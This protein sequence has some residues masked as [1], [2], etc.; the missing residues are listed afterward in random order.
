MPDEK[1]Q[2]PKKPWFKP[3]RHGPG[4]HPSTWQGGLI[5]IAAV[6]VLV[7]IVYF[8]LSLR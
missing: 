1:E 5:L 6:V 3:N 7:V 4:Y 8:L 2:P